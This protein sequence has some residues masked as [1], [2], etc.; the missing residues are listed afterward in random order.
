MKTSFIGYKTY[1]YNE[2]SIDHW[3]SVDTMLDEITPRKFQYSPRRTNDF[4]IDGER[5]VRHLRN[6]GPVVYF[7]FLPLFPLNAQIELATSVF[8]SLKG[9]KYDKA[10]KKGQKGYFRTYRSFNSLVPERYERTP[11][12]PRLTAEGNSFHGMNKVLL[13]KIVKEMTKTLK[14]YMVLELDMSAC[15]SRVAASLLPEGNLLNQALSATNFWTEQT[16]KYIQQYHSHNIDIDNKTLKKIFKVALYTA[17]NGGNPAGQ[18]RLMDNLMG[19]AIDLLPKNKIS[20]SSFYSITRQILEEFPL[21]KEV[22][23]LNKLCYEQIGE[24]PYTYTVDRYEPYRNSASYKGISRVLQGFEVV[25]LSRLTHQVLDAGGLPLSLDHDG[26][27]AMFHISRSG[28]TDE[29]AIIYFAKQVEKQLTGMLEKWSVYLLNNPV[30]VETKRVW[31]NGE[32][33]EF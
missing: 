24:H 25:L 20:Q 7:V 14:D 1:F 26:L 4:A 12:A 29:E 16:N 21:L 32:M 13:I 17:L 5:M 23:D 28:L 11:N 10:G 27:L 33:K 9:T 31:F 18:E 8:E 19:N 30:P 3:L 2:D 6:I 15:H 22:R